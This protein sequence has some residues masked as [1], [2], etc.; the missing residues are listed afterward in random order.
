ME[1]EIT[2][3]DYGRVLWSGRWVLLIAAIG[4]AL[5]ALFVSLARETTYTSSSIVYMGLVTTARTGVPVSTPF[6]T[7]ATAQRALAADEFVQKAADDAGVAFD[8]VKDGVSFVVERVPGAVGG[9]QPTVATV[10]YTDRDR[11]T[12]I[13]VTNGYVDGVFEVVKG[14]YQDVLDAEQ[15]IVDHADARIAQIRRSLDQARGQITPV[16]APHLVSLQQ[17][18]A[19]LQLSADE[20]ALVLAK[21]RQIEQPRVISKATSA[22]SSARPGQRLRTIVFG[23]V[24]GLILGTIVT[25]I[26]RG[27]PAGRAAA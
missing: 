7:P 15:R 13:R 22:A 10:R 21:T 20:A 4:G 27:S 25:F 1:K 8:R 24:L 26:W 3:S 6:T 5:I 11:A 19:T 23:A 16:T 14:F 18:L 2:L 12:A 17:E 9:N